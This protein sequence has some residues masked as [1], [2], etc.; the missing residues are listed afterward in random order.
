M[1]ACW[2]PAWLQSIPISK[3]AGLAEL[4]TATLKQQLGLLRQS[5]QVRPGGLRRS[6]NVCLC[7]CV[8]LACVPLHHCV[9]H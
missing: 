4:D 9:L 3:L 2:L 7:C 5:T 6:I 1:C 8:L